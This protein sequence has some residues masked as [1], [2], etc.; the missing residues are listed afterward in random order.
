[1]SDATALVLS[2]LVMFNFARATRVRGT[3]NIS[4]IEIAST[5]R[6]EHVQP[7]PRSLQVLVVQQNGPPED[8]SAREQGKLTFAEDLTTWFLNMDADVIVLTLQDIHYVGQEFEDVPVGNADPATMLPK[9]LDDAPAMPGFEFR[10]GGKGYHRRYYKIISQ[11]NGANECKTIKRST[12][13]LN[14]V[15]PVALALYVREDVSFSSVEDVVPEIERGG[16]TCKGTMM[17]SASFTKHELNFHVV[18]GSTH[19]KDGVDMEALRAR[20]M[21]VETGAR[22]ANELAGQHGSTIIWGGDFNSRYV[23]PVQPTGYRYVP[24]SKYLFDNPHHADGIFVIMNMPKVGESLLDFCRYATW[25][26]VDSKNLHKWCGVADTASEKCPANCKLEE[27]KPI[28]TTAWDTLQVKKAEAIGKRGL[29]ALIVR[30]KDGSAHGLF[31]DSFVMCAQNG[32]N[33]QCRQSQPKDA[34]LP[35]LMYAPTQDVLGMD[36]G[37]LLIGH[38]GAL[39]APDWNILPD[40]FDHGVCL[41]RGA[42]VSLCTEPFFKVKAGKYQVGVARPA[43]WPDRIMFK[44][45]DATAATLQRATSANFGSDHMA[46]IAMFSLDRSS[47]VDATAKNN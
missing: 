5:G 20:Y 14:R 32:H 24:L 7:T 21:T 4:S 36:R 25:L 44:S 31:M 17:L 23:P 16:T 8:E 15:G 11:V 28:P 10:S 34:R 37:G 45:G 13:E 19:G 47:K 18:F 39:G 40:G 41:P 3:D 35:N 43:S 1:M 42:D 30:D 22:T 26:N 33:D 2:V 9:S 12:G 46:I 6:M 38:R 27:G 29:D